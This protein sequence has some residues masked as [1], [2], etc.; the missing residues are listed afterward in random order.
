MEAIINRLTISRESLERV[1]NDVIRP[2][3][4]G[5]DLIETAR[6]IDALHLRELLM[7]VY[8]RAGR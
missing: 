1:P 5:I 7:L 6:V 2:V 3:V 8:D 4:D